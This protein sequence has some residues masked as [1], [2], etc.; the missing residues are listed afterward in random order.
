[1]HYHCRLD[2]WENQPSQKSHVR[3]LV[4]NQEVFHIIQN[5]GKGKKPKMVGE[6]LVFIKKEAARLAHPYYDALIITL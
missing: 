4:S 1:M 2:K 3:G 5:Q 6:D